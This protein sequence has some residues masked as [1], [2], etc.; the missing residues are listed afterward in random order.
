MS[1][2]ATVQIEG[3]SAYSQS[4]YHNTEKLPKEA[5]EDYEARTWREKGHWNSE[6]KM[7]IP[8]MSIKQALDSAVKRSGKQIPGKGKATYTKH[9]TGGCMVFEPAVILGAD[10]QPITRETV[11]CF[12]GMMSSTGEKGKTGGKVV[13]RQFP[14]V[15]APWIATVSFEIL[16][17]VITGPIFEEMLSETGKFIGIG[18]FR[19]QN[20]GFCGR[21][22]VEGVDW[23]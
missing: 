12:G 10:G 7:V 21:F 23:N 17:E 14:E 6:G 11:G 15:D 13:Y 8:P 3:M 22:S 18:R 20:G 5:H 9:F 1:H 4:R 19:P 2:T 16:D